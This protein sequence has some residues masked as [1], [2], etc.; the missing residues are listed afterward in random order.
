M[1][2]VYEEETGT[3]V[4]GQ[5]GK[6]LIEIDFPVAVGSRTLAKYFPETIDASVRTERFLFSEALTE[7]EQANESDEEINLS[8]GAAMTEFG[9]A[10]HQSLD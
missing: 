9:S 1:S 8:D 3:L 6:Y 4:K 10:S 2:R 5:D 7:L